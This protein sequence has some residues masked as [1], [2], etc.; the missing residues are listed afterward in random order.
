MRYTIRTIDR[1][2]KPCKIKASMH[3]SRLMAYLD[4]LSRN[5][6]HGIVVEESV[7]FL[8]KFTQQE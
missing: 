5:G 3:E 8:S 6:H 2:N 4:A 7:V 1:R